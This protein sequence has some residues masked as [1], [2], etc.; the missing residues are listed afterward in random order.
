MRCISTERAIRAPIRLRKREVRLTRSIN[1]AA[2]IALLVPALALAR[3]PSTPAERRRAVETTRKLE[4]DPLAK[5][6]GAERRWLLDWIIAIPDIQVQSCSGPLDALVRG[7]AANGRGEAPDAREAPHGRI[8]YVQSL[9]GMAAFLIENPKKSDDWVGV[10]TAGLESVLRAYESIVRREK[11]ARVPAL[12]KLLTA[13]NKRTL[14]AV[15]TD[16]MKGCD[17]SAMG[18]VPEDSI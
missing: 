18:P 11:G 15:V 8:L 12:D 3:G 9:F 16:E 10:Q 7:E 13:R 17:P 4:R 5:G 14:R 2:A 1:F 6:A